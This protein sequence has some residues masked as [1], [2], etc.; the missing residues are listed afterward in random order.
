MQRQGARW[1]AATAL[2]LLTE[3]LLLILPAHLVW[4]LQMPMKKKAMILV[5]FWVRLP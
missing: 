5:A 2:D 4:N 1:Q 3:L